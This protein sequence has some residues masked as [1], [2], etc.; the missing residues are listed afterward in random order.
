MPG[1]ISPLSVVVKCLQ[2]SRYIYVVYEVFNVV[3]VKCS[4]GIF[5]CQRFKVIN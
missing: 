5:L 2:D 4:N 3:I 1:V